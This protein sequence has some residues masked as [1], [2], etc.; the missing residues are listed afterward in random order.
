MAATAFELQ[1]FRQRKPNSDFSNVDT[2][3]TIT[4]FVLLWQWTAATDVLHLGHHHEKKL[5][6]TPS[7][8]NPSGFTTASSDVQFNSTREAL[9]PL[10]PGC[11]V[12][13]GRRCKMPDGSMHPSVVIGSST[14]TETA[15]TSTSH[16]S[17]KRSPITVPELLPSYADRS[18]PQFR[19]NSNRSTGSITKDSSNRQSHALTVESINLPAGRVSRV[20]KTV[21]VAFAADDHYLPKLMAV[22]EQLRSMK[23][24]KSYRL[25]AYNL[26]MTFVQ[27]VKI[28]ILH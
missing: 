5:H 3:K 6:S 10:P 23:W 2:M 8:E 18:L 26:G 15:S 14:R 1:S 20:P 21:T 22:V 17:T 27:L 4:S 9:P 19:D 24:G 7:G 13:S 16:G 28:T 25:I 12:I 11:N